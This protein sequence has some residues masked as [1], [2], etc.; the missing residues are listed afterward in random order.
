MWKSNSFWKG[1]EYFGQPHICQIVQQ[2]KDEYVLLYS[3]STLVNAIRKAQCTR[4]AFCINVHV[5]D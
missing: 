5:C 1:S 2:I 3:N 4:E